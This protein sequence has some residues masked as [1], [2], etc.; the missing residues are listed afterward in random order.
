MHGTTVCA[1]ILENLFF[2]FTPF[3]GSAIIVSSRDRHLQ[4]LHMKKAIEQFPFQEKIALE[5][6]AGLAH[7]HEFG[8]VQVI[9]PANVLVSNWRYCTLDDRQELSVI[10]SFRIW[11][12]FPPCRRSAIPS[13]RICGHFPLLR[14]AAIPS[15]RLLGSPLYISLGSSTD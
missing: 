10:P 12:N 9:K 5:T 2:D 13:F 11:S 8:I 1:M 6:A 14:D 15:F 7:L 4:H 3:G